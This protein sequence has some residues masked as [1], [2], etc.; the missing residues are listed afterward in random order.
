MTYNPTKPYKDKILKLIRQTWNTPYISVKQ[1]IYPVFNRKFNYPE[2]DHTDGIGTKGIYHWRERSFENAV[3]DALAMNLN[4]L[5]MVRATPY[6]LQCHISLPRDDQK[7]IFTIMNSLVAQCKKYKIAITGGETSIQNTMQG[8]DIS[9]TV[10]GFVKRFKKNQFQVDDAIVGL[11]S[12]GLHS[13]GFTIVRKVFGKKFYKDFTEPTKIYIETLNAVQDEYNIHG[14]MHITG[15]AYTKL[16]GLLHN[17][18][19]AVINN[20]KLKPQPIFRNL[21]R[22]GVSDLNM[23]KTFNC[24]VGFI[25]ST[26]K[27]NA[28]N[29]V[30]KVKDADII[31]EV[32]RGKGKVIIT[33]IFSDK[34]LVI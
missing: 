11:K 6:K 3:L 22:N 15:G 25:L 30:S 31:G 10:S 28:S 13:N 17:D 34:K 24:G 8:L 1:A 21:Y 32:M 23:H 4:D 26:S 33:S 14:M 2:V 16:K 27:N 7:A 20:H 12:N 18:A 9:L 29:I 19:D 5:A